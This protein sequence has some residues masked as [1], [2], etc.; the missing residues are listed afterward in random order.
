MARTPRVPWVWWAYEEDGRF[1]PRL[2]DGIQT[3]GIMCRFDKEEED[4][5]PM[6]VAEPT[7]VA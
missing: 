5:R 6:V 2:L 7:S 3:Y 4:E 1:E